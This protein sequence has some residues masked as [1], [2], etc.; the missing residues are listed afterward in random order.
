MANR[1][2][3]RYQKSRAFKRPEDQLRCLGAGLLMLRL[4]LRDEGDLVYGPQG[5][6][7]AAY[8]P[9]FNISH[10]GD[11]VVCAAAKTPG[12]TTAVGV[13]VEHPRPDS[14]HVAERVFTARE[15]EWMQQGD[16]PRRFC[17]LWTCK[18]ALIKLFGEGLH[19]DPQTFDVMALIHGES[20]AVN[21]MEIRA[22]FQER[23]GHVLCAV[24][25][26]PRAAAC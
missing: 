26:V 17:Q 6:P 5:K 15:I 21:G 14:L 7:S 16:A 20:L 3:R 2:P 8:L 13:D 18:E 19:M 25:N 11:Y 1:L 12:C 22:Q 4:G 10:S 23:D 9:A 24:T